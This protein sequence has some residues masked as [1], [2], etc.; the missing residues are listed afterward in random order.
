M[1]EN[2]HKDWRELCNNAIAAGD[3]DELLRII[4]ELNAELEH[5]EKLRQAIHNRFPDRP[6]VVSA[7][8]R[9]RD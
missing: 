3:T 1:T 7:V 2:H 8:A 5:E 6:G 4:E 9:N